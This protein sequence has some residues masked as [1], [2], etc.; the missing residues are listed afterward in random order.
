MSNK[1][2]LHTVIILVFLL[3]MLLLSCDQK[4]KMIFESAEEQSAKI[5]ELKNENKQL[6]E[7][8]DKMSEGLNDIQNHQLFYGKWLINEESMLFPPDIALSSEFD[9]ND[10]LGQYLI[11][12][13]DFVEYK[14][15]R[16]ENPMYVVETMSSGDAYYMLKIWL[17]DAL[18]KKDNKI[19]Y[20]M[21]MVA[22]VTVYDRNLHRYESPIYSFFLL[23]NDTLYVSMYNDYLAKRVDE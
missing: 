1:F 17:Q 23:N 11:I 9:P 12:Q 6:R 18:W 4:D 7:K 22:M 2:R 15:F 16:L 14:G 20:N 10:D 19:G 5:S 21:D 8:I 3:M 13:K